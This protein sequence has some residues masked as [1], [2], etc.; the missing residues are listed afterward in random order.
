MLVNSE[1][2]TDAKMGT[3]PEQG[4]LTCS[5][6]INKIPKPT[7]KKHE[8][9]LSDEEALLLC[10]DGLWEMI[11][12]DEICRLAT[13]SNTYITLHKAIKTAVKPAAPNSDNV[14]AQLMLF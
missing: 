8:Q 6:G 5:I 12:N 1:D 14:T 7:I 11:G 2:I 4:S 9:P 3:H 13:S 10:T